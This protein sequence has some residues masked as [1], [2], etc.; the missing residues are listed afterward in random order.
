MEEAVRKTG[1]R[2]S[3]P[4]F[5]QLS[6]DVE[7]SVDDSVRPL[8]QVS[9]QSVF[10][11]SLQTHIS[12]TVGNTILFA[13]SSRRPWHTSSRVWALKKINQNGQSRL[14]IY[15]LIL[16]SHPNGRWE[17]EACLE[18]TS[19]TCLVE[20]GIRVTNDN[21]R[22]LTRWYSIYIDLVIP[23]LLFLKTFFIHWDRLC[24][25]DY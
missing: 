24:Y 6:T 13:T 23:I 17:R 7:H 12:E 21:Y 15:Y 3:F 4:W 18:A 11:I 19:L 9:T 1:A 25:P 10:S 8:E 16:L 5:L 22:S 14:L 2:I 20:R